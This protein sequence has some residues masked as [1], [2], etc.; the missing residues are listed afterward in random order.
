MRVIRQELFINFCASGED[1]FAR[2]EL[3]SSPLPRLPSVFPSPPALFHPPFLTPAHLIAF[4]YHLI[5]GSQSRVVLT[6][7]TQNE[8]S[9]ARLNK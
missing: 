2:N 6:T 8:L 1:T 3:T 9:I 4:S 7:E 5:G